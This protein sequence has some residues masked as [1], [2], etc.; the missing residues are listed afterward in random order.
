MIRNAQVDPCRLWVCSFHRP[1]GVRPLVRNIYEAYRLMLDTPS[2][3]EG[4][5]VEMVPSDTRVPPASGS[6]DASTLSDLV[7]LIQLV[8]Q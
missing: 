3:G 2:S 4:F 6:A 8:G 5:D 7:V 1:I